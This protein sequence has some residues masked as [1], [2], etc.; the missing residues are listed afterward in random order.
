MDDLTDYEKDLIE[1]LRK[2]AEGVKQC[3]TQ[4][5]FQV[6][7]LCAVAL[8]LLARFQGSYPFLGLASTAVILLSLSVARIGTFKYGTANRSSGYELYLNRVC[9]MNDSGGWK[10]SYRQIGREEALRAWRT[11]QPTIFR[12]YYEWGPFTVNSLK[13]EHRSLENR[14]R[15]FSPEALHAPGAVY[16][17]GS[18]LRTML[19]ILYTITTFGLISMAVMTAQLAL[20][21]RT[22][23]SELSGVLVAG[24]ATMAYV[25]V[26]H[27][28]QRRRL[29][30]GGI[31][32]IHSSAITWQLV[33]VAHHRALEKLKGYEAGKL[34]CFQGY[35]YELSEQAL[36]LV[37]CLRGGGSPHTWIHK[38]TEATAEV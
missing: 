10:K 14:L 33:V 15:W 2:E 19:S 28:S 31:L 25:R 38:S 18:Y 20:D 23:E 3:F 17:A 13:A 11:I 21:G 6:I 27:L 32:C 24:I 26:S 1:H 22:V 4:F 34:D 16:Y 30:E 29:L 5:S 37:A 35:T 7:A 9:H 8:G 36:D 12:Y